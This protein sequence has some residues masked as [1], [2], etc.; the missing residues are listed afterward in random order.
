M[1]AGNDAAL[2]EQR[3][4][5]ARNPR[6]VIALHNLGVELRKR[7]QLDEALETLERAVALGA[8]LLKRQRSS[9]ICSLTLDGLTRRWRFI[10]MCSTCIPT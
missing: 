4:L 5:V 1:A 10:I 7:D 2:D 6:D 9:R 8:K 3:R